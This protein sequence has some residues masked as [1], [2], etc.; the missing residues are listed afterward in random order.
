MH[1]AATEQS[2]K[3]YSRVCFLVCTAL[4]KY[5]HNIYL[6]SEEQHDI[7]DSCAACDLP[8]PT[9]FFFFTAELLVSHLFV[10]G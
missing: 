8:Q 3:D 9:A 7:V 4:Y 5:K 1:R 10:C 6:E 2:W